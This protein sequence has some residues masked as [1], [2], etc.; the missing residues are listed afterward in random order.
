MNTIGIDRNLDRARIRKLLI[1]GLI[2][3][4]MTGAGDFLLGFGEETGGTG[5]AELLMSSAPNL[6][7]AQLIWGGLLGALGLFLEGLSFFAV[8]RLMAD[9]APKYAHIYRASIFG[10][11]WLAPIGCHM[12]VGLMNYAYKNLL[13]LDAETA[14]RAAR[15]MVYAFCVPLWAVLVVFWLPGLI[16]QFLAF[17]KGYTPYPVWA[18]WFHLFI[19]M[20]P[21]LLAAALIGPH[22]ACGAGIGMTFLSCGNAFTFGGLLA[23]LPGEERFA[24]F[25][26]EHKEAS[27]TERIS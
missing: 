4:V 9:A 26:R 10:Y 6:S 14:A 8:Y 7:D 11:I 3:S 18:K 24:Q 27:R 20:L 22:T 21:P 15:V 23:A 17:S 1:I 19:G 13:L 25:E 16:V 2:A 12:N 5:F